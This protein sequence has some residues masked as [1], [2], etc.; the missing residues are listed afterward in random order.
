MM[1]FIVIGLFAAGIPLGYLIRKQTFVF[2]ITER[3]ISLAILA[4]LFFLGVSVGSNPQ[5][6]RNFSALG[7]QAF[8]LGVGAMTGSLVLAWLA[9]NFYQRRNAPLPTKKLPLPKQLPTS[10]PETKRIEKHLLRLLSNQ[11]F[12]VLLFFLLGV[13]SALKQVVPAT[14]GSDR[15]TTFTLYILMMLVGISIGGDQR[16]LNAVRHIRFRV[17]LVPLIVVVGSLGGSALISV[18]LHKI[19]LVNA[20]AVGAG[21]GYYSL[22][23]I[24]IGQISGEEMGV[25]ALLAN[26][27]R[28][29]TTLVAAP[30]MVKYFGK[31]GAIVSAGA[32]AMDTTLPVIVKATGR[33]YAI[34]SIFSGIALTVLVPVL[35]PFILEFL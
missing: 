6:V 4:L 32:T 34:V 31:L 18:L 10:E 30:F 15:F 22:S 7:W 21:F 23:S 14:L 28:E 16:A 35:V 5:V 29:V 1:S 27:L 26:I 13:L 17:L 33:E 24:F 11:S 25:V 20:L 9:T 19:S 12:R 2:K 3:L 8:C